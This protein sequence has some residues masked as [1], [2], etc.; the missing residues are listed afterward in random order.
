MSPAGLPI[1]G[2]VGTCLPDPMMFVALYCNAMDTCKDFYVKLG[3]VKAG[4]P[5]C[6]SK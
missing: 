1:R 6:P 5:L 3:F 2:V 4:V